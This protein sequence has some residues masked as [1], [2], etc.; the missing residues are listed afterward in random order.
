MA[1][2][3]HWSY[4][5]MHNNIQTRENEGVKFSCATQI[6]RT[7]SR[8]RNNNNEFVFYSIFMDEQ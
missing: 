7:I 2:G 4:Y 3:M 5:T 1:N 8:L 6:E